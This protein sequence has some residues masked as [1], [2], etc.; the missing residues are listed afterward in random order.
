MQT[1]SAVENL[2]RHFGIPGVA[3][4]CEGNGG[5]PRIQI[6]HAHAEGEIYLHGAQVTSWKPSGNDE[7]LFLSTK[8]RWQEGQAI[9]GGIPICFPWFRAKTDNPK[10]PAHGF[11]RTKSWQI[12]SIEEDERGVCVSMSTESDEQTRHW[13]PD[14]FRLVY[15][16]VLGPELILEL[17]CINTGKNDLR[18]EEA[19]HTYNRVSDVA[20][21]RLRGLD[22][23]HFLDNN[24]SNKE[25]VQC[26]DVKI[27]AATD[28][29]FLATRDDVDLTD[30]ELRRHLRL[31]K[32][33][34]RTTVV[35]N[36]WREG[37]LRLVDLGE[38][39]WKQFLC[40]EASNVLSESVVL[41]PGGEHK[42]TA[43]L[44]ALKL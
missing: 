1:I 17:T 32:A 2:D 34:S 15:R 21:V 41:P 13:W 27:A 3:R 14:E 38:G 20:N 44:S 28:N 31:Q 4:I 5:L 6:T 37:A 10:A 35:W 30:P 18:F 19:L 11:V 23:V 33:N 39:E 22:N 42:M 7:V 25:N 9:R 36:P 8:S 24:D 40:V 12:E 26:G 43:L 16:V 29:A